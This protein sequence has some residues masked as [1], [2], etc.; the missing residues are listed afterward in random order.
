M[1]INATSLK[2]LLYCRKEFNINFSITATLGRQNLAKGDKNKTLLNLIK[3]HISE[4]SDV[5][6]NVYTN[7]QYCDA[8]LSQLGAEIVE[9][10]DYS[11]YE[12]ASVL[13]D[14]NTPI[15]EQIKNKYSLLIDGGTTEHIFNIPV[16]YRNIMEMV[17]IGGYVI[18]MVPANNLCGH[19]F[20]Q[21][22]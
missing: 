5:I 12:N 13:H 15:P 11:D 19:G 6:K 2:F 16:A 21:F 7:S 14:M 1:G 17:T 9:S 3:T 4:D 20:Y 10:F 8:L 18:T 22:S